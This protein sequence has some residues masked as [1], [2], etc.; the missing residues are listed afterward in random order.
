MTTSQGQGSSMGLSSQKSWLPPWEA[1]SSWPS[2]APSGSGSLSHTLITSGELNRDV[3][4]LSAGLCPASPPGAGNSLSASESEALGC[5]WADVVVRRA[6]S[7]PRRPRLAAL[8]LWWSSPKSRG[9][10][11]S[12]HT[13][14]PPLPPPPGGPWGSAAFTV[15]APGPGSCSPVASSPTPAGARISHLASGRSLLAA[16]TLKVS[17]HS[18]G[19]FSGEARGVGL[20][21]EALGREG[22]GG[23]FSA[24]SAMSSSKKGLL[25]REVRNGLVRPKNPDGVASGMAVAAAAVAA[26]GDAAAKRLVL[27]MGAA[28]GAG[29]EGARAQ[30]EQGRW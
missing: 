5:S 3:V 7:D 27:S 12:S 23:E 10:L 29:V 30:G 13:L 25:C 1:S 26:A 28:V 20:A 19:A 14:L 9:T 24:M 16:K 6:P 8:V 18:G 17:S 21:L 22:A 15:M 11:G 2:G 4:A